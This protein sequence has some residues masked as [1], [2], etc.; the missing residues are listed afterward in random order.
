MQSEENHEEDSFL[1]NNKRDRRETSDGP[2]VATAPAFLKFEPKINGGQACRERRDFEHGDALVEE[3]KG[4]G[5]N[6]QSAQESPV[7]RAE[8][9]CN[10]IPEISTH[11]CEAQNGQAA[12]PRR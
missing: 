8:P 4:G 2:W 10:A 9:F 6:Y 5:R 11:Q 12:D 7:L 3:D 1:T